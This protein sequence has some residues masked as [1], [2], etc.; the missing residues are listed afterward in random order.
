MEALPYLISFLVW[1]LNCQRRLTLSVNSELSEAPLRLC[2]AVPSTVSWEGAASSCCEPQVCLRDV[3]G[4][5]M[6]RSSTWREDGRVECG[7]KSWFCIFE[8]V[9]L[10]AEFW[11]GTEKIIHYKPFARCQNAI[12][13]VMGSKSAAV[14]MGMLRSRAWLHKQPVRI[15]RKIAGSK[16]FL[17]FSVFFVSVTPE[18]LILHT[19]FLCSLRFGWWIPAFQGSLVLV[20]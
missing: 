3:V 6:L 1:V 13:L 12:S 14:V 15:V 9:I 20:G 19:V 18:C 10:I 5:D 8:R 2:R 7:C 16:H 11:S 17:L 4:A